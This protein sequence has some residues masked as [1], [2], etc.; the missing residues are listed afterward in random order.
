MAQML[1][2]YDLILLLKVARDGACLTSANNTTQGRNQRNARNVVPGE[3]SYSE[4]VPR[5]FPNATTF[6][7]DP[8]ER[9]VTKIFKPMMTPRRPRKAK[10]AIVGDSMLRGIRR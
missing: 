7:A 8:R 1:P 9:Q 6:T 10:V 4:A 5:S 2:V 3:H